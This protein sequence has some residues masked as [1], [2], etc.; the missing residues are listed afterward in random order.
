MHAKKPT[1]VASKSFYCRQNPLLTTELFIKPS[2]WV[3]KSLVKDR[4]EI[5]TREVCPK[6]DFGCFSKLVRQDI[7]ETLKAMLQKPHNLCGTCGNDYITAGQDRSKQQCFVN[8]VLTGS[9]T[10]PVGAV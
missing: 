7:N 8:N 5:T 6:G 4:T 3:D 2:R 10:L 1:C 9:N